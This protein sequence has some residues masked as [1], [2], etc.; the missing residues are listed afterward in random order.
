MSIEQM[1]NEVMKLYSGRGW[2]I[3]VLAMSDAQIFSI[4]N[5]SVLCRK[6]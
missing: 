6:S 1:R 2:Q 4:Y 5:K 3:R